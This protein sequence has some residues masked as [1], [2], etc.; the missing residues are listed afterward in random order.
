VGEKPVV[1]SEVDTCIVRERQHRAPLSQSQL[2]EAALVRICPWLPGSGGGCMRDGTW[3]DQQ[4]RRM[5]MGSG[6]SDLL[7][8]VRRACATP[9][10]R[11]HEVAKCTYPAKFIKLLRYIDEPV[12]SALR[13]LISAICGKS[14]IAHPKCN[15]IRSIEGVR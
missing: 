13:R 14:A 2:G 9:L 15:E 3:R 6:L 12:R 7:F 8:V 11:L 1:V 10:P 4:I 5:V